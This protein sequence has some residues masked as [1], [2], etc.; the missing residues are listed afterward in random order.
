MGWPSL[1]SEMSQLGH[2]W[3]DASPAKQE[4]QPLE[5]ELRY[6]GVWELAGF[7][8]ET[9]PWSATH[10]EFLRRL[11]VDQTTGSGDIAGRPEPALRMVS[12]V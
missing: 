10:L 5:E 2:A 6:E 7:G 4:G 8:S 3:V 12:K 11:G 9:V 1:A